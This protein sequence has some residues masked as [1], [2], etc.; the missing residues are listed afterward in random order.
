MAQETSPK[1]DV[2]S[3]TT[4]VSVTSAATTIYSRCRGVWVG[5]TQSIDLYDGTNWT[6]F[7]GATAGTVIPFEA[8][9]ARITSGGAAPGAGDVVFIY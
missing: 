6:T 9:A 7:Q 3:A 8:T 1:Y 2:N 5:T 4:A